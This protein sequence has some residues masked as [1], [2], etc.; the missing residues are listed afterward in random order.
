MTK[1]V[2]FNLITFVTVIILF[3]AGLFAITVPTK[4][5]SAAT[6][7]TV[8]GFSIGTPNAATHLVINVGNGSF[9]T[10]FPDG[11]IRVIDG[12][13]ATDTVYADGNFSGQVGVTASG[14]TMNFFPATATLGDRLMIPQGKT[15]SYGTDG[16]TV[17]FGEKL[18]VW[19]N[20]TSWQ[21]TEPV[22]LSDF[23]FGTNNAAGYFDLAVGNGEMPADFVT[24]GSANNLSFAGGTFGSS[25]TW[26]SLTFPYNVGVL[27]SSATNFQIFPSNHTATAGE[28]ITI[29]QGATI[30]ANGYTVVFGEEI[31]VTFD[32]TAWTGLENQGD[33]EVE[34]TPMTISALE[35]NSTY[36]GTLYQLYVTVDVSATATWAGWDNNAHVILNGV[37]TKADGWCFNNTHS[38]Y[39][40][41]TTAE[42]ANPLTFA[43]GTVVTINNTAYEIANDFNVYYYDGA[44]HTEAKPVTTPMT[45]TGIDTT[46]TVYASGMY[47]IYVTTNITNTGTT[48]GGWDNSATVSVNST[49]TRADWCFASDVL[50]YVQVATAEVANPITIAQGT[51]ITINGTLYEISADFNIYHYDG[52][53][54][55]TEKIEAVSMTLNSMNERSLFNTET[56]IYQLYINVNVTATAFWSGWDNSAQVL[57]N[58]TPMT[59]AG[60]CFDSANILYLEVR[61]AD[62][63]NPLTI[64]QGTEL[65]ING[66]L[67]EIANDFSIYYYNEALHTEP[68]PATTLMTLGVLQGN[69]TF[70]GSQYALYIGVDVTA[71]A[72]WITVQ[73]YF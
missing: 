50:L 23:T 20:G 54:H 34:T 32:G 70:N 9:P 8:S 27:S 45:I 10:D 55:T 35:G 60:W 17:V 18:E 37:S 1:R 40:Q 51:K 72:T 29:P 24:Y 43:K 62:A 56:N 13:F 52:G 48:W 3:L 16:N 69:S 42:I 47:Q 12:N 64:Q 57:F 46:R 31:Q 61:T 5:A 22:V 65:T 25:S 68:K 4:T 26:G 30:I 11:D 6:Q 39:M 2:K 44:L 19:Y 63:A 14:A 73:A 15:I 59:A 21:M 66:T 53:F 7:T 58:G 41:L 67:Y 36:N 28:V 71:T 33:Q 38:L 49:A